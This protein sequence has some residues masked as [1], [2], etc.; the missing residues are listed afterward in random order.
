MLHIVTT[1]KVRVALSYNNGEQE[2]NMKSDQLMLSGKSK[3]TAI[4]Y[5]ITLPS[6]NSP[7]NYSMNS[8]YIIIFG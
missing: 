4:K 5:F 2:V 1:R 3:S 7:A 8:R 6:E